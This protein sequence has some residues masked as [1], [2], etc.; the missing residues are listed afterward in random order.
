M[1]AF[2]DSHG[3]HSGLMRGEPAVRELAGRI[4]ERQLF[5]AEAL[6]LGLDREQEVVDAVEERRQM[7]AETLFW[8]REVDD[9]AEVAPEDDRGL[10]RPDR[11]DAGRHAGR[12]PRA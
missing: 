3:G 5:V 12:D 9:K 7:L 1:G 10:L 6:A 4:V 2:E 11:C 8:K